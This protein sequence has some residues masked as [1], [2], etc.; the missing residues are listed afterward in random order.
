MSPVPQHPR[1]HLRPRVTTEPA[2]SVRCRHGVLYD[3]S[4]FRELGS[5][6]RQV[7]SVFP[8]VLSPNDDPSI[9]GTTNRSLFNA[10]S[11]FLAWALKPAR[12]HRPAFDATTLELYQ[13]HLLSGA[14]ALNTSHHRFAIASR[15]ARQLVEK[16]IVAPFM[17][18][19]NTSQV[20]ALAAGKGSH[21]LYDLC[22]G[23]C[24]GTK[25][26]VANA[27][28][29]RRLLLT[30]DRKAAEFEAR[31]AL[32]EQWRQEVSAKQFS[33]PLHLLHTPLS[34]W[35]MSR[36][37]LVHLACKLALYCWG[38][39]IQ[40]RFEALKARGPAERLF[41][42]IVWNQVSESLRAA[43]GESITLPEVRSYLAPSNEYFA[44]LHPLLA[45]SGVNPESIRRLKTDGLQ[46]A[47]DAPDAFAYLVVEK[48][49]AGG[50]IRL[51][52]FRVGAEGHLSLPQLWNRILRATERVRNTAPAPSASILLLGWSMKGEAGRR[53]FMCSRGSGALCDNHLRRWLREQTE[54]R[55]LQALATGITNKI[56]RVTAINIAFAR[57]GHN[58]SISSIPFG[59]QPP[60]LD[61]TYLISGAV[62]ASLEATMSR[63]QEMLEA[64]LRSPITVV[65]NRIKAV[66]RA[67]SV[68]ED[69]ARAV[70][71]DEWTRANGLCLM[72][73]KA[74]VVDSPLN[75]LRMMQWLD[76]LRAAQD[77]MQRDHPQR[78]AARYA[79]QIPLFED[80]LHDFSR[81]TRRAAEA[82]H[83]RVALPMEEIA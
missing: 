69:T 72:N 63:A 76:R 8:E 55:P 1:R 33:P 71:R 28:I 12:G 27:E 46:Y 34:A 6:A 50:E 13:R 42:S 47:P 5:L 7:V 67:A 83:R 11:A 26:E 15:V 2:L 58:S 54:D 48:P 74:L 77:R 79:P 56:V 23:L 25:P 80:A 62:R 51:G 81:R 40:H 41:R 60:V 36:E 37:E 65:D 32:G 19:S 14:L 49:R 39:V 78:W 29:L 64:W 57:L 4:R 10:I 35:S 30:C 45:A 75:C 18:P 16:G 73:D 43:G 21:T 24:P 38:G 44:V 3:F 68:D 59:H 82:L 70:L 61:V 20:E 53:S 52:P 9:A 31:L 17:I 22:P 66:C